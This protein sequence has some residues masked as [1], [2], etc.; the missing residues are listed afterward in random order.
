MMYRKHTFP[1][2][3]LAVLLLLTSLSS[4][5][6]GDEALWLSAQDK[7]EKGRY[8]AAVVDLKGL[9]EAGISG[10]ESSARL[11]L[12]KCY[13]SLKKL[14]FAEISAKE[15]IQKF[16]NSRYEAHGKYVLA[17]VE[18]RKKNYFDSA[19]YLLTCA[20]ITRDNELE[21]LAR[22]KLAGL[23][24]AHLG[25]RECEEILRWVKLPQIKRELQAVMRGYKPSLKI[26]LILDLSGR[27]AV[28]G[29]GVLDG[30][31][32]AHSHSNVSSSMGLELIVRD[33]EGQVEEAVKAVRA[34]IHDEEVSVIIGDL[35][36]ECTAAI[37]GVTSETGVPQIVPYIQHAD[38]TDIG[39]NI[40]QLMPGAFRE[41]A[42]CAALLCNEYDSERAAILA[43]ANES[44]KTRSEGFELLFSS[45]GGE[46]DSVQWYYRGATNY[47]RQLDALKEIGA[48]ALGD[49]L[50]TEEEILEFIEWDADKDE[51][52]E[53]ELEAEIDSVLEVS[54]L[55][56]LL[57]VYISPI[58]YFD[59]LYVPIQGEEISYLAPQ[60]AASGFHGYI[61]CSSNCLDQISLE[62]DWRYYNGI[63][64]PA[65]FKSPPELQTG[66]G[67]MKEYSDYPAPVAN[68]WNIIG[69]DAF[70]YLA[71]V[72]RGAG[73]L[74]AMEISKR[75]GAISSFDGERIS[76]HFSEEGHVNLSMYVLTFQDGEFHQLRSPE[77]TVSLYK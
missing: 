35:S 25:T 20:Q 24:E 41:G 36:D 22:E 42:V 67:F 71:E 3:M 17:Q 62:K 8:K 14:E 74:N 54:F 9:I 12:A 38:F 53:E 37:A 65:H 76:M 48:Y 1:L 29:Q 6:T 59:A 10:Y 57:E 56:S 60:I 15:L 13:L 46:I 5:G 44:G 69:W 7:Y 33:S 39:Q 47:K 55:D 45:L 75:L 18:F 31:E 73:Y 30:L 66:S 21:L 52:V 61:V 64:F 77:E 50:L 16:P 32:A 4:A 63:I 11:L 72:F 51:E 28:A 27:N 68:Q 49:T 40:F 23:F 19:M 26:G 58:N 34:L 70:N 43:P 2:I